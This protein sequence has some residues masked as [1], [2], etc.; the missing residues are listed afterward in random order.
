MQ[1]PRASW[2][3]AG[4]STRDTRVPTLPMPVREGL[5][6]EETQAPVGRL[7]RQSSFRKRVLSSDTET[8][9]SAIQYLGSFTQR[10]IIERSRSISS[11]KVSSKKR[12]MHTSFSRLAKEV[13]VTDA[14]NAA[15][16]LYKLLY[17]PKGHTNNKMAAEWATSRVRSLGWSFLF[18]MLGIVAATWENEVLWANKRVPSLETFWLKVLCVALSSV[19]LYHLRNYYRAVIAQERLH[20]LPLN[21]GYVSMVNLQCTGHFGQALVDV[22]CLLPMPLP[23]FNSEFEITNV[24]DNS[25]STYQVDVILC[26]L[27]FLRIRFFPRFFGEC[28]TDLGSDTA[29]AYGNISRLVTDQDFIFKYLINS[30]LMMVLTLWFTQI[31]FF[32]YCLMLFERPM[33]FHPLAHSKLQGFANCLWCTVITMTIVGYGDV[34]PQT[35][36]GRA[37]MMLA[38]V[39]A[40]IMVAITTNIVNVLLTM[41]RNESKCIEVLSMIDARDEVKIKAAE[42]IQAGWRAYIA[43]SLGKKKSKP[44]RK[45]LDN[46][47]FMTHVWDFASSSRSFYR[48]RCTVSTDENSLVPVFQILFQVLRI[49]CKYHGFI[50]YT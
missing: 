28:V 25:T 12:E 41:N 4:S 17:A 36:L 1:S 27:M 11:G 16:N 46:D 30:N 7:T 38:S 31:V 15:A 6:T 13:A 2:S 33:Q 48:D 3:R 44:G 47:K 49:E 40:L 14:M 42:L 10:S 32:G 43:P 9:R 21:N 19:S 8:S 23:F 20:G 22:I 45:L 24:L 39:S 26:V 34:Y 50:C 35:A 18:A 29:R 5:D 37:T